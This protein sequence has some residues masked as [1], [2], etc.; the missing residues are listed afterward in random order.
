MLSN[1]LERLNIWLTLKNSFD[2][3]EM[4]E[5]SRERGVP[6]MTALIFANKV[7]VLMCAKQEF[8]EL[9][10]SE[11]LL[12]FAT[13]YNGQEIY[14]PPTIKEASVPTSPIVI[15]QGC[16]GGKGVPDQSRG[17]GDTIYKITHATGLDKLAE[18]YT[19][20]TG[21]PCGCAERQEALNK[22]LPYGIKED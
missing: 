10:W 12:A 17:V 4:C 22:L 16:C 18:L 8:P 11:A 19:K 7:G 20:I 2:Y 5:V 6:L 3:V 13:K 1:D 15:K 9:D 21:K 14:I